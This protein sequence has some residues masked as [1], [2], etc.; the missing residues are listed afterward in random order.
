MMTDAVVQH[1]DISMSKVK[2]SNEPL[3]C[4]ICLGN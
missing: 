3:F 2:Q 4:L 1:Y